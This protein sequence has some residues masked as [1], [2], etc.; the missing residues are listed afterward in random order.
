[1]KTAEDKYR[2]ESIYS[3]YIQDKNCKFVMFESSAHDEFLLNIFNWFSVSIASYC[4]TVKTLD[5]LCKN[6]WTTQDL[7]DNNEIV[8]KNVFGLCKRCCTRSLSLE[9]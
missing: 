8:K 2:N 6:K 7:I 4:R 9:K 3:K 5:L 1:M